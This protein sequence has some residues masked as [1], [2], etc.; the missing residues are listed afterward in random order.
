MYDVGTNG[1]RVKPNFEEAFRAHTEAFGL[2]TLM[3]LYHTLAVT[4]LYVP[5]TGPLTEL[6]PGAFDVPAVCLRGED[7]KGYLLAFTSFENLRRWKPSHEMHVTYNGVQVAQLATGMDDV[8]GIALNHGSPDQRGHV[9]R[10]D[11]EFLLFP[12]VIVKADV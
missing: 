1:G 2:R 10:A 7:G 3:H 4:P 8:E 5:V 6:R 12:H 9:P 11:Y